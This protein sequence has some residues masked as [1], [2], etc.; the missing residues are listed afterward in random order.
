MEWVAPYLVL[1]AVMGFFAGLLGVG[2]GIIAVPLLVFIFEAQQLP[3][4]HLLRLAVGTAMASI[5]FTSVSSLLAHATRGAVRWD[6]V[7]AMTPGIIA[8]GLAGSVIAAWA[9]RR[10]LAVGFVVIVCAAGFSMLR[11]RRPNP[12]RALPGALGL[13]AVG[14]AI[15]AVSA[16]AA[17]GGAFMTVP[18]LSWCNVPIRTAIGVAA[19]L[20]FPI[21]AAG[22]LGYVVTGWGA[23]GLPDR[24]LGY[25][26][27]PALGGLVVASM[28][29]APV[30]AAVAHRLA[31]K[32]LRRVFAVLLLVLAAR[33]LVGIW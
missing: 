11:E 8:G 29:A 6:V 14:A 4:E 17:I 7:R 10:L 22:T 30:G 5:L 26:Y 33:M 20:G 13:A 18:F 32:T 27:L 24:A 23:A 31:V 12:A 21:A 25:V 28:L 19:A 3:R 1:G 16:F 15:S 2:G 9:P